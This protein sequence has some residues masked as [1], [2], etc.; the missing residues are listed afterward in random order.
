MVVLPKKFLAPN[1]QVTFNYQVFWYLKSKSEIY[2]SESL[3]L[4]NEFLAPSSLTGPTLTSAI[5]KTF[6]QNTQLYKYR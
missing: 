2:L 3:E 1:N 6:P 5:V 4:V